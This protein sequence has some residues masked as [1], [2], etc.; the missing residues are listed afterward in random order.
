MAE[1]LAWCSRCGCAHG[2][3]K[4]GGGAAK[5]SGGVVHRK[6]G[7]AGGRVDAAD[8]KSDADG[9]EGSNPSPDTTI[10]EPVAQPVEQGPFKPQAAGSNPAGFAMVKYSVSWPEFKVATELGWQTAWDRQKELNRAR[11]KRWRDRKKEGLG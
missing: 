5:K 7:P 11:Q 9:T 8:L 2:F 6:K 3:G 1:K 4:H 10:A